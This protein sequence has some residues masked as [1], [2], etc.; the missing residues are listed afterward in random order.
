[1]GRLINK[2]NRKKR[3]TSA[4]SSL[5]HD[6]SLLKEYGFKRRTL[7]SQ[8]LNLK[9]IDRF[10]MRQLD[11]LKMVLYR[12]ETL[13]GR[14]PNHL[15]TKIASNDLGAFALALSLLSDALSERW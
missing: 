13:I 7:S 1:L 2:T 8:D 9:K 10:G 3:K 6:I 12:N 5:S 11:R 15:K 4:N 14:Y